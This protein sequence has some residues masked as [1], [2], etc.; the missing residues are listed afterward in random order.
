MQNMWKWEG[1]RRDL[2]AGETAAIILKQKKKRLF[3]NHLLK[4]SNKSK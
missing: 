1:F 4:S 2:V 3:K